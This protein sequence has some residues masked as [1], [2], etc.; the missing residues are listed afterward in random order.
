[1]IALRLDEV[2]RG[3]LVG[4][5]KALDVSRADVRFALAVLMLTAHTDEATVQHAAHLN[6]KGY[7]VKPVS[8][9]QLGNRLHAIFRDR[10][11]ILGAALGQCP[12]PVAIRRPRFTVA[13]IIA[14]AAHSGLRARASTLL[15]GPSLIARPKRSPGGAASRSRAR[16]ARKGARVSL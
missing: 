16:P 4:Q 1:M 5:R 11:P 13:S 3:G 10:Q 15:I 2:L 6:I 14:A 7:L 8:P 9:T 12:P